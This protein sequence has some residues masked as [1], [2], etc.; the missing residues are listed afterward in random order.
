MKNWRTIREVNPQ[1]FLRGAASIDREVESLP[2]KANYVGI[3]TYKDKAYF[4][5]PNQA[6]RESERD[7]AGFLEMPDFLNVK[8]YSHGNI[9]SR[10]FEEAVKNYLT[11]RHGYT[12]VVTRHKPHYL[13]PLELDVYAE[14]EMRSKVITVCECKFRLPESRSLSVTID[15][16]SD[17]QDKKQKIE[18]YVKAH[19]E[20]KLSFWLVTN[21]DKFNE[22]AKN[23]AK[24]VG[25]EIRKAK[26]SRDW[27]KRADWKVTDM[28]EVV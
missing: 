3:I 10:I 23:E 4:V 20:A 17:F 9:L 7:R 21:G 1:L 16:L 18:E 5:G 6:T 14:K 25:I 27:E 28:E 13:A 8:P 24:S 12:Y 11:E 22:D 19:F 15:D 2:W 26:L